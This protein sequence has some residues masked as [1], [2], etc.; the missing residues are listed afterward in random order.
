MDIEN[1]TLKQIREIAAVA[2]G[3]N[4]TG[5]SPHSAVGKK[6]I[7]RCYASGIHFGEVVSINSNEG[8]SRCE[9]RNSRRIWRWEGAL[10]VSEI[11]QTGIEEKGS[12]VSV[13]VPQQFIEDA[14]EFL[15]A[16]EE[17]VKVLEGVPAYE[18]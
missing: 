14:I 18:T 5:K 4:A 15:P 3:L 11:S 16:S 10:S 12:K 2:G 13:V 8:R 9:L 7:V 6:C 1:L 17:A